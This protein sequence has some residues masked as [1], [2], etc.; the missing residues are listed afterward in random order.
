MASDTA[1]LEFHVVSLKHRPRMPSRCLLLA[2]G[3]SC[4]LVAGNACAATFRLQAEAAEF[5]QGAQATDFGG[6]TGKGYVSYA[7]GAGGHVE[8]VVDVAQATSASALSFR[9][10]NGSNSNRPLKLIVNGTP[11]AGEFSFTPTGAW[12][13][14]KAIKVTNVAL[15]QGLNTIRAE[16]ASA[17]GGPALDRLDVTSPGRVTLTDWAQAVIRSTTG[18]RYPDPALFG[19]PSKGSLWNYQ[20]GLFLLGQHHTYQRTGNVAYLDYI[21]RWVDARTNSVT[22]GLLAAQTDDPAIELLDTVMPGRVV[23]LLDA[24]FGGTPGTPRYRRTAEQL[25][26]ALGEHPRTPDRIFW[27]HNSENSVLLD[28]AYMALPFAMA[29]GNRFNRTL[30][31]SPDLFHDLANQL[32]R[33]QHHL[34][35]VPG[36]E[37][38]PTMGTG[39]F[40]HAY[41]LEGDATNHGID[42]TLGDARHSGVV[43]CRGM[44]WYAMALV[45]LLELGPRDAT[46]QPTRNALIAIFQTLMQGLAAKQSADGRWLTVPVFP[47]GPVVG[48]FLDTSCSAMFVYAMSKAI[49]A[50]YLAPAY[51][52]VAGRAYQGVLGQLTLQPETIDGATRYL[53]SLGSIARGQ[54]VWPT[55]E[56]YTTRTHKGGTRVNPLANDLH[57]LG[58][59]LLMYEQVKRSPQT[60]SPF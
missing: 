7:A 52:K 29:H 36:T 31:G 2:A 27:H 45:D 34:Q 56:L 46:H 49:D 30:P 12:S 41:D 59:F 55:P 44:G 1:A 5:V 18:A 25:W 54:G 60:I 21:R 6:Y 53:T 14:W 4:A 17:A 16:S 22:G 23:L 42:W 33:E 37:V 35:D 3:L 19:P 57:G 39:L 13:S 48:N 40:Y 50:G 8:W 38:A 24:E 43:W 58:A 32:V 11:I 20:S 10:A 47:S 51:A 26:T 15:R 9:Y 28:G